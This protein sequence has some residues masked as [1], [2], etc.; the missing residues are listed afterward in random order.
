M[1]GSKK[2]FDSVSALYKG[3]E[4]TLN[5]FKKVIFPIKATK[6]EIRLDMLAP[7]LLSLATR[8]KVLSPKQILQRLPIAIS[9]VKVS[10]T[11]ENLL[12]EISQIIYSLY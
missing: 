6:D 1:L 4:L 5:A 3:R 10:N 2:L 7:C 11:H 12:N 9:L 8:L